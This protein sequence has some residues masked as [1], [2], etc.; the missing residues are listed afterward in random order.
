MYVSSSFAYCYHS[1]NVISLDL[2]QKEPIKS[3]LLYL[4]FLANTSKYRLQAFNQSIFFNFT[5]YLY[6]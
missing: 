2:A 6:I 4:I 3:H 1:V 5:P